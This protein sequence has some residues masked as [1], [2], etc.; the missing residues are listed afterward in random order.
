MSCKLPHSTLW[1]AANVRIDAHQNKHTRRHALSSQ[2]ASCHSCLRTRVHTVPCADSPQCR[3]SEAASITHAPAASSPCLPGGGS[4]LAGPL[5][6]DVQVQ[7][8]L[9]GASPAVP[10]LTAR[11]RWSRPVGPAHGLLFTCNQWH[12]RLSLLTCTFF[13]FSCQFGCVVC[14]HAW[15][16]CLQNAV[17]SIHTSN[18]YLTR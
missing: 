16:L 10:P 6:T 8:F 4:Q 11:A 3:L 14:M 1:T 9:P 15:D 7:S 2:T 12:R 18:L 13:R 5:V 17:Y